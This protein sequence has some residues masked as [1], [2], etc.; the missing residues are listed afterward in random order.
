MTQYARRNDTTAFSTVKR[1]RRDNDDDDNELFVCMGNEVLYHVRCSS[2]KNSMK[3]NTRNK[4]FCRVIHVTNGIRY[5]FTSSA[6][7]LIQFLLF[8]FFLR[9][10][11]RPS[12]LAPT[13]SVY[14]F[15]ILNSQYFNF[16]LFFTHQ[17]FVIVRHIIIIPFQNG[18]FLSTPP[19]SVHITGWS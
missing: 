14:Q 12:C 3:K 17:P 1:K 16:F 9:L 2:V 10:P 13:P 8:F 7:Y 15:G 11:Q 6:F 18:F 5:V 4:R 19:P